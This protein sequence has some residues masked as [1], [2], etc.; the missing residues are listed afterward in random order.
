MHANN[1]CPWI[2]PRRQLSDGHTRSCP[3]EAIKGFFFINSAQMSAL[4][5]ENAALKHKIQALESVVQTMR[6]EMQ[7]FRSILGPWFQSDVQGQVPPITAP[8]LNA[9]DQLTLSAT[10]APPSS[11]NTA[12][13]PPSV[14]QR[15]VIFPM[16]HHHEVDALAL[17]FPLAPEQHTFPESH[18]HPRSR[19]SLSG[20]IVDPQMLQ[21]ALPLTPV[22]P[23]N[24]STSLEGSLSGLRD[25]IAAVSASVDSLARRNDIALTNESMRINE[26]L[27][28]LKYAV[29]GIRLQVRL[30]NTHI[31]SHPCHAPCSDDILAPASPSDDG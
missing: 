1:G 21:R 22:A 20:G 13:I 14:D 3:Y 31:L 26:E 6:R 23:L 15:E 4:S 28:S 18:N 24:L 9:F 10:L 8:P 16:G 19:R 27:G 25:S 11:R 7:T 12:P 30:F 5:T 2:G 17:Y 29:H